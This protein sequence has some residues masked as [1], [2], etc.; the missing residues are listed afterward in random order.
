M[1]EY[2]WW[3][4]YWQFY[5]KITNCHNLLLANILSYTVVGIDTKTWSCTSK[6]TSNYITKS[7]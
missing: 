5:P 1:Q 6:V 4:K 3:I 2:Y 7:T